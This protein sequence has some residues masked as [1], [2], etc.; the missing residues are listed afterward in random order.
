METE[1]E[2]NV[3]R[4]E[5]LLKKTMPYTELIEGLMFKC[6]GDASKLTDQEREDLETAGIIMEPMVRELTMLQGIINGRNKSDAN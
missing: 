2:K 5:E 6:G 1:F 4:A 3:R